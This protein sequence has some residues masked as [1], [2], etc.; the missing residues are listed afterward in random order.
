MAT[1]DSL[2]R[3][4]RLVSLF[5]GPLGWLAL[6]VSGQLII[7]TLIP[8]LLAT[9][10]PLDV[11]SDGLSWGHEWQWGYYKHP[12][13]PS[14]TV[15]LF[16][17]GLGD[18]GP[19]LLS[20]IA[21]ALTYVFVFLL[22]REF[23]PAR[24]AATGTLLL[25][26]V[27]YFSIP[28]PEFNHNV[29]QMPLWAAATFFYFK[30]WKT[31]RLRWWLTLGVAAALGLLAKYPTALLLL[32]MVAHL[33]RSR[34]S[35][36][37][38]TGPYLATAAC[39]V[40]V[41]PHLFWLYAS[42]FPT[43]HYAVARAGSVAGPVQHLVVPLKFIAAQA[44]DIAPAAIVAAFAGLRAS[45]ANLSCR[46]ENLRFLLWLTLGP[47]LLTFVIS[48]VTGLGIRDM[49]GAPMWNLTG[50]VL[51]KAAEPRWPS[52]S[53]RRLKFCLAGLFAVG[54][55]AYALANAVVPR[56]E[57]RP[58]RTQWPD[59][60]IAGT[61]STIW[62][63]QTHQPLKIIA[64]DGWLAGLVAM[65]ANPRPSVWIDA[66]FIKSPWITQQAVAR[67][68]AL[69]VW[70]IRKVAMPAAAL[71]QLPG[72]TMLGSKSFAWPGMPRAEP[73]RIGYGILMPEQTGR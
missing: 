8:W 23:M 63:D 10:L 3:R 72:L 64:G 4:A 12:P 55:T 44:I 57:N 52:V 2:E 32:A 47:L 19:F 61:L 39:T 37:L 17:D 48:L 22:G 24:W 6:L 58:S 71:S 46:D 18:I 43:L 36:F 31:N 7:W 13:L 9:S 11:V 14:W 45:P 60:K 30:A 16:F 68:G 56:L 25:A 5:D 29:A 38:S 15:E 35:A 67:E 1:T 41:S 27:Y 49:W 21:I 53:P 54:L 51:V 62:R 26:G 73:L 33:A 42:G 20:Q 40:I 59:R 65:R 66:S 50:L 34:G 28:T 70:R 69:V